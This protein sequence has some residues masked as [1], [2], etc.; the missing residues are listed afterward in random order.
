VIDAP[1]ARVWARASDSR[2]VSKFVTDIRSARWLDE[3]WDNDIGAQIL[4]THHHHDGSVWE[5][6]RSIEYEPPWVF[7]WI[8]GAA[9]NRPPSGKSVH[10]LSIPNRP[11]ADGPI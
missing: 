7:G 5:Q 10:P 11:N 3:S 6:T 1:P 2:H 8:T 4:T 9:H